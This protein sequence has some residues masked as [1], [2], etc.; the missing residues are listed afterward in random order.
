MTAVADSVADCTVTRAR[1]DTLG[2]VAIHERS[3]CLGWLCEASGIGLGCSHL[4]AAHEV[5]TLGLV[6]A[7]T[8]IASGFAA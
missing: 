6:A 5:A 7:N 8:V 3:W 2:L 1:V 4:V